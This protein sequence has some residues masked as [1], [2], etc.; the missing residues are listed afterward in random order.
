VEPPVQF[1]Y[2]DY[3]TKKPVPFPGNPCSWSN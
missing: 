3:S 2:W 1:S